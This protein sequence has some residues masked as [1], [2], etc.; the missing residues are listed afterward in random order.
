MCVC[1]RE[2]GSAI[3]RN[4]KKNNRLALIDYGLI[5]KDLLTLQQNYC[6]SFEQTKKLPSAD[7]LSQEDL[8][9]YRTYGYSFL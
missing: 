4:I 7:N 5:K 1:E 3:K 6:I 2:R 8:G 9:I